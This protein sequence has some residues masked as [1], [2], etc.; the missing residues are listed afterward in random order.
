MLIHFL[1]IQV[2]LNYYYKYW[3]AEIWCTIKHNEL[4]PIVHQYF[5]STINKVRWTC[6]IVSFLPEFDEKYQMLYLDGEDFCT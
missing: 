1:I 2:L 6:K 3:R 5:V 4:S